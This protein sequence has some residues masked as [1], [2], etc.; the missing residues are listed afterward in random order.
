MRCSS[1]A[2]SRLCGHS[3]LD[4]ATLATVQRR[5]RLDTELTMK[6]GLLLVALSSSTRRTSTSKARSTSVRFTGCCQPR[7][8]GAVQHRRALA[9]AAAN[10]GSWLHVEQPRRLQHHGTIWYV[11][12]STPYP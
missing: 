12:V 4:R 5:L 2:W 1:G 10:N 9:K 7:N 8:V 3:F 11:V 6:T